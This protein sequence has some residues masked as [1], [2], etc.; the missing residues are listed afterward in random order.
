MAVNLPET[1]ESQLELVSVEQLPSQFQQNSISIG[2][3]NTE[4]EAIPTAFDTFVPSSFGVVVVAAGYGIVRRVVLGKCARM[5]GRP[6]SNDHKA[7]QRRAI[8]IASQLILAGWLVTGAAFGQTPGNSGQDADGRICRS[9]GALGY[10]PLGNRNGHL[11]LW[12]LL[13]GADRAS[14]V[15][16]VWIGYDSLRLDLPRHLDDVRLYASPGIAP[17]CQTCS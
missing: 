15:G 12:N 1:K 10:H 3:A 16:Q 6:H 17:T 5:N 2:A 9:M 8:P 13:P 4:T 14:Y 7:N 11:H